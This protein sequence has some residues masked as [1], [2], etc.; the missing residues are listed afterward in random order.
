MLVLALNPRSGFLT[1][2]PLPSG[3]GR[4]RATAHSNFSLEWSRN[5]TTAPDFE[6]SVW[7]KARVLPSYLNHR[8]QFAE[9]RTLTQCSPSRLS[10][11]PKG[12][13]TPSSVWILFRPS[14]IGTDTF[15][16]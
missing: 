4:S 12:P 7:R 1:R 5:W 10:A 15:S 16:R 3:H 14:G 11:S 9:G 13:V 2:S 8:N 6:P